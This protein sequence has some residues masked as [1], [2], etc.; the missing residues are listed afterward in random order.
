[1]KVA[2]NELR[3]RIT[4]LKPR[5]QEDI[6]GGIQQEFGEDRTV[7]AKI[8]PLKTKP[9]THIHWHCSLL[10]G[11]YAKGTI[12]EVTIRL[13]EALDEHMRFTWHKQIF[14]ILTKPVDD[15]GKRWSVFL[16]SKLTEHS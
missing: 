13:Y 12:Y 3:E 15:C 8:I 10:T 2:T 11:F 9:W 14:I 16:A 6:L 4:F 5:F 7:W 1:M